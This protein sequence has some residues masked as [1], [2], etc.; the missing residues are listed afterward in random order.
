MAK[1]ITDY[2][3]LLNDFDFKKNLNTSPDNVFVSSLLKIWWKCKNGHSYEVS[4]YS[5]L[6]S[7]GCK[8]CYRKENSELAR[9]KR[10]KK[11]NTLISRNPDF[12][13]EWDYKKNKDINPKTISYGSKIKVWFICKLGHE[14]KASPY[15]RYYGSA[16]PLCKKDYLRKNIRKIAIERSGSL[17]EK[18]PLLLDEWN[19]EKNKVLPNEISPSSGYKAHWKC[20]FGHKWQATISNRTYHSSNCPNCNPQSS[21][22]EIYLFC[23]LKH[24]ISNVEW[25]KKIDGVEC[26]IFIEKLKIGIEIDGQFWHKNK[27]SKDKLK[28]TFFKNKKIHLI[29]VREDGLPEIDGETVIYD[30]KNTFQHITNKV[31]LKLNSHKYNNAINKY[32]VS[33]KQENKEEYDLILTRLPAPA[34]NKSLLFTHPKVAKEWDY[35]QNNPFTPEQF[36]YGAAQKFFWKCIENHVWEA[37]IKNR[38]LQQSGCPECYSVNASD[39]ARVGKN[40]KTKTLQEVNP[41]Y[42]KIFNKEKNRL[43]PSEI[44]IKSGMQ[45]NWKCENGHEFKKTPAQMYKNSECSKC[46]TL[47][48]KSPEIANE[49]NYKRNNNLKPEDLPNGSGTK[50]WWICHN[51]HEWKTAIVNRTKFQKNKCPKCFNDNRSKILNLSMIKKYGSLKEVNPDFLIEWDYEKN[52]HLTP[53]DISYNSNKKVWWV[54]NVGHS[55]LQSPNQKNIKVNCPICV[56]KIRAENTRL[57]RIKNHG[58]LKSRDPEI[59]KYWDYS[60]NTD[61][62]EKYSIGSKKIVSWI[63]SCGHKW[64]KNINEMTDERRKRICPSCKIKRQTKRT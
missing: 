14:W 31:L 16:C 18:F 17:S 6:R 15:Q 36:T 21:K 45:I 41:P 63:C 53:K 43:L 49:W 46:H 27:L 13:I 5:R 26:D 42:L 40:N 20:Q 9:L 30:K 54:C 33:G 11:K 28:N 37:T 29:R 7:N 50:V 58:S 34:K 32:L 44:A 35:I 47:K 61:S 23:E 3:D 12:L 4:T 19:Y 64:E 57:G 24:I 62:P 8:F 56:K 10:L 1:N 38:T 2:P 25:R 60:I 22:L 51:G 59:S 55:Y 48:F 52:K 39:I